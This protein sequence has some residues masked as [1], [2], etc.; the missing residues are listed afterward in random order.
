MK[1]R[2]RRL[3]IKKRYEY[4]AAAMVVGAMLGIVGGFVLF[5]VL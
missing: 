5:A 1:Q 4:E 3:S 2:K